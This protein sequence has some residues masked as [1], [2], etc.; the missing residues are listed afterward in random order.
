MASTAAKAAIA[1]ALAALLHALL[2][3]PP[4]AGASPRSPSRHYEVITDLP[5][6]E[7]APIIERVDAMHD[8][9]AKRFASF[10]HNNA[11]RLHLAVFAE[12]DAYLAHL[13][14]EGI[15]ATNT[16]GLFYVSGPDAG[17]ASYLEP[18]GLARMHS[19]LQHEG[20]HLF[21]H[22]HISPGLPVWVNEGLAEYFGDGLFVKERFVL[23][24]ASADRIHEVRAAHDAGMTFPLE[25]LMAMTNDEWNAAVR[26]GDPRAGVLYDQSWSLVHFLLHGQRGKHADR[27]ENYL[28]AIS[29]GVEPERAFE[30]AFG[31]RD[32][33]SLTR[34]WTNHIESVE[35][36]AL[37]TA[38]DRLRFFAEGLSGLHERDVTPTSMEELED[39]L[40]RRS[41]R[42]VIAGSHGSSRSLAAR[43]DGM[44]DP[45]PSDRRRGKTAYELRR[46][47]QRDV[48]P[49]IRVTGLR[50]TPSI[51]W[52]RDRDGKL[53]YRIR[54]D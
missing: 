10:G 11:K 16:A 44:F 47:A 49:S 29:R 34:A 43:D 38:T 26:T 8:A 20:F 2:P 15:D 51:E 9:L 40:K 46:P 13:R 19:T 35:P 12:A 50:T 28:R 53:T 1:I 6:R 24:G 41:F 21:A 17:V 23:G 18:Q 22:T 54:Y 37:F 52:R 32:L 48:P 14:R 4:A 7:A 3:A 30:Q 42:M 25:D 5:P 33:T 36:D 27:F 39:Q 31:T 45:P